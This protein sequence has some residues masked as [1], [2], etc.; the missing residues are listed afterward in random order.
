MDHAFSR[1]CCNQLGRG[2]DE[3]GTRVTYYG[4]DVG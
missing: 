1:W 3:E 4:V 2:E